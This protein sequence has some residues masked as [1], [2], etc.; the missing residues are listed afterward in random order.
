MNWFRDTIL[1]REFWH[2]RQNNH[3][4]LIAPLTVAVVI[5]AWNEEESIER[6][7]RS[8]QAQDQQCRIIVIDDCSTDR[9]NEIASACGVE[10][11]QAAYNQGS[12]AR[13]INLA[14]PR[15]DEDLMVVVDADTTLRT[16]SLRKLM[17]AF[18]DNKVAVACGMVHSRNHKTLWE[19]S[20][21]AEYL[22]TQY[23]VKRAQGNARMVLVASGCFSAF[24]TEWL[25]GAGGFPERTMAEDMDLT[26]SA[27]ID[28][29]RVALVMNAHCTVTDPQDWKTYKGQLLR[30][31]RGFMQCLRVRKFWMGW[32]RL[33][34]TAYLY[35]FASL[36]GGNM[37]L[38]FLASGLPGSMLGYFSAFMVIPFGVVAWHSRKAGK[39]IWTIVSSFIAMLIVLP[40]N[41]VLLMQ[42]V[43]LEFI[44]GDTLNVWEKG[45]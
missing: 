2:G 28:G 22:C 5:P 38:W 11:L 9:T 7:I 13:A 21:Y 1:S 10:V 27:I 20:R 15:I 41:L 30:W 16:N 42:S 12:K 24:R 17:H 45:H 14:I 32:N 34:F 33:T 37:F 3:E 31:Y 26:W 35:L 18:S 19:K 36:V 4:R 6:T 40:I 25:K 44:K 23:I 43:Y 8:V 39:S 29:Y